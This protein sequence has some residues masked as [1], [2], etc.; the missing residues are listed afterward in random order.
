[1]AEAAATPGTIYRPAQYLLLEQ[2][3]RNIAT[4]A[5][6]GIPRTQATVLIALHRYGKDVQV[7]SH[8]IERVTDLRQPEVSIAM[9]ILEDAGIVTTSE[10]KGPSKGRP[11]KVYHIKGDIPKYIRDKIGER[12]AELNKGVMAVNKI[13]AKGAPA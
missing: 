7:T 6:T 5:D 10:D 11:H 1:M 8:W 13:F 2:D 4:L 3:L 12:M 9:G